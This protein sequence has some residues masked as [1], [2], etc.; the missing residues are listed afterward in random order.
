[1]SLEEAHLLKLK[2]HHEKWA[3]HVNAA[4]ATNDLETILR[5][6]GT[7]SRA[8]GMSIIAKRTGLSRENLYR[9]FGGGSSPTFETTVKL[10]KALGLRFTVRQIHTD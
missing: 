9:S 4:L 3:V 10:L 2:Y 6:M 5:V 8:R 7:I 1:M